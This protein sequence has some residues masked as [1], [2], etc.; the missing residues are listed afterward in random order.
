MYKIKTKKAQVS[1]EIIIAVI[2]IIVFLFIFTQLAQTTQHNLEINHIKKEQT[3][4]IHSLNKLFEINTSVVGT[5]DYFEKNNIVAY[6]LEYAIPRVV[7][8][9]KSLNCEIDVNETT[10]VVKNYYGKTIET[11][12]TGLSLGNIDKTFYCGQTIECTKTGDNIVCS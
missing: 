7:V 3:R 9:S 6:D 4:M 1:F 2:F 11:K 5:S 8:G 12:L 10:I